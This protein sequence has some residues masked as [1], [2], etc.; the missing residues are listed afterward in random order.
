MALIATGV[1]LC[2]T[3]FYIY[4]IREDRLSKIAK[5]LDN[6]YKGITAEEEE[7]PDAPKKKKNQKNACFWLV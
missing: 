1:G 7:L 2:T 3:S 5:E 6:K 4:M